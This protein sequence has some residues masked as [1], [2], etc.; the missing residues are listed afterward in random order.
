MI[1]EARPLNIFS[2]KLQTRRPR[3]T[4]KSANTGDVTKEKNKTDPVLRR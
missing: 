4:N 3:Q 1:K 2:R